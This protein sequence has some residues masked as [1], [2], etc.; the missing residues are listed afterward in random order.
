MAAY[1]RNHNRMNPSVVLRLGMPAW[2]LNA[3]RSDYISTL[4]PGAASWGLTD[5]ELMSW[6]S[7]RNILPF[8]YWDGPTDISQLFTAPTSGAVNVD[9]VNSATPEALPDYPGTGA[10]TS[11]RNKI[12]T[13]MWAEGTWLGL[14]TGELNI[15]LVR[16]SILN[17]Q[18]RFRNFQESWETPAFVGLESL[19]C[20]HTCASDGSYGAAVAVTL[21]AGSGL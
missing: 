11:F 21:G 5:A 10:T 6:F 18:N 16:D 15:G 1:Y 9:G 13:F 7:D 3:M 14:T 8:L 2:A 20:V 17:S 12:V 4:L 19:R